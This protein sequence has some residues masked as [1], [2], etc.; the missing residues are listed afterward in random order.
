MRRS[1]ATLRRRFVL[2]VAL[3][4]AVAGGYAYGVL[5]QRYELFPY[6]HLGWLLRGDAFAWLASAGGYG[7]TADRHSVL[8]GPSGDETLVLV[9]FGQSNAANSV[10]G[11]FGPV[12]GVDNFNPLDGRCYA[13]RDPLLGAGGSGGSV[14]MPLAGEIIASGLASRVIVVPIGLGGTRVA[15]WAPGGRLV[16]RLRQ[17]LDAMSAA[18]LS[19][20]AFLWH[21][22]ESD[23]GTARDA[24]QQAF[25]AMVRVIR[26]SGSR[27]PI[28]VARASRCDSSIGPDIRAAQSD[29][30]SNYPEL[31]LRSGPDTDT[32]AGPVWR[33]GCHF[34]RAGAV[35]H[36]SLW[37]DVLAG[38]I[39][40][41][42]ERPSSKP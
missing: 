4:L 35:R 27:A 17:A 39:R 8:C 2:A 25:L 33:E 24:Y 7:V 14:W 31:G 1:G 28:Y 5:S 12:T 11:R 16:G 9:T 20:H 30:G 38:D 15:D 26:A 41:L 22:G 40:E 34:T 19:A 29:L 21:Q 18:G 13:A 37:F 6:H 10:V 23:R 32:L 42:R 36:A 3:I